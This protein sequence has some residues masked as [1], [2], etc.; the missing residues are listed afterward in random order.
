MYRA[1]SIYRG[2][3]MHKTV[4]PVIGSEKRLPLYLTGIG[5]SDPEYHVER[6]NSLMQMITPETKAME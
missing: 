4:Y 6:E 5:I 2:D 3:I 1:A